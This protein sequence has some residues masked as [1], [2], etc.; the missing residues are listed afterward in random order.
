MNTGLLQRGG[1]ISVSG[2]IP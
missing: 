2:L 1:V